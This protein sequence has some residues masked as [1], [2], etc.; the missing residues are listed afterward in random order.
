MDGYKW[1]LA[2]TSG[3]YNT[4]EFYVYLCFLLEQTP[5]ILTDMDHADKQLQLLPKVPKGSVPRK[6]TQVNFT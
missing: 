4:G 5:E 3:E 1:I 2:A 6:F